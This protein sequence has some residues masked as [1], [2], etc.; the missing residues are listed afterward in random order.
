[1]FP[2]PWSAQ[3]G[4]LESNVMLPG[5]LKCVLESMDMLKNFLPVFAKNMIDGLKANREQIESY[6]EKSPTIVTL[7]NPYIGYLRVG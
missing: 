5:M 7:L 4:Q 1:M 2:W 6:V 3:A